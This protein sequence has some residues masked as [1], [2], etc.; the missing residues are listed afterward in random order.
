MNPL[1]MFGFAFLGIAI[2]LGL[3]AISLG[4][5]AINTQLKRLADQFEIPKGP[6]Q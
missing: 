1:Q 5:A 6:K 2:W 3:I 4:L